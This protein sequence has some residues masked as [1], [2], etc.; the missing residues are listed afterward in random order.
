MKS[1]VDFGYREDGAGSVSVMANAW[2]GG[3]DKEIALGPWYSEEYEKKRAALED[4]VL[5]LLEAIVSGHLRFQLA[6]NGGY[7]ERPQPQEEEQ[8]RVLGQ[9]LRQVY[10]LMDEN[11]RLDEQLQEALKGN[12]KMSEDNKDLRE[13]LVAAKTQVEECAE[14]KRLLR[15]AYVKIER[16]GGHLARIRAITTE[17][18][19]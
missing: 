18:D 3:P 11:A 5:T 19:T 6:S 9:T 15:E 12:A 14:T 4:I 16:L 8:D 7:F 2:I 1:R 10:E 13:Q 17:K